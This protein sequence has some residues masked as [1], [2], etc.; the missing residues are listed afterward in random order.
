MAITKELWNVLKNASKAS[1]FKK[2]WT[3]TAVG[4]NGKSAFS[5]NNIRFDRDG[6]KRVLQINAQTQNPTLKNFIQKNGTH[7]KLA[8]I[9]VEGETGT[10]KEIEAFVKK[11][12]EEATK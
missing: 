5:D 6:T 7:K 1:N 3:P 4:A 10:Q 2:I 8:V 12:M 11:V 9:D